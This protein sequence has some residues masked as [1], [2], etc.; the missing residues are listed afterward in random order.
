[1]SRIASIAISHHRLPL[2]PPFK[3]SWDGRPR[4]HFDATIVRVRDDEGREG[5][6]SGD[7][8]LGFAGHEN[9]FLGEDPRRVE[10]HYEVLS[11]IQFHYGRCWPLDLA[12]WDLYGKITGEPVWRLLGGRADRVR[13]YA[14]SGVLRDTAEMV[15]MAEKFAG[16]GFPAM[17]IRFSSSAGGRDGWRADL[18]VLEAIRA[19]LGD[20]LELMVDCNQGWRMPWDTAAPWTYKDA[21]Q[22]ARELERLGVYWMEEPL[23][24]ADRAGMRALREATSLRIAGGEMTREL[25][26]FRDLIADRALDILQPDVA[27]VGGITGLRRVA[28]MAREHNIA[29]TPHS[30]TNGIGVLANAHLTAGIGETP[31][32]E[33]PYDPPEW[34]PARRDFPLAAPI[35]HEDGWLVLG[36]APGLGIALDEERLAATRRT[37]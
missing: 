5:I 11:H 18:K 22:V 32:L 36:E 8:M 31:W 15:E 4:E 24:R 29:F 2:D 7:L 17:K 27:L 23:H 9:L 21:L 34:S 37:P 6:G 19:R 25:H 20:R 10:R 26:D 12:L 1:M 30:W 16:E 28:L 13:L 33:F 3:A 35:T 14:S